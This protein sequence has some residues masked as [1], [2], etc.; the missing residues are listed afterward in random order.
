MGFKTLIKIQPESLHNAPTRS[1]TLLQFCQKVNHFEAYGKGNA[2]VQYDTLLV[3]CPIFSPK[4]SK[5]HLVETPHCL[6][7]L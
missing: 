4:T 3:S 2:C 1:K 5:F 6:G 7:T